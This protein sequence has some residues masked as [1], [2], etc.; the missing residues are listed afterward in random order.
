MVVI[1]NLIYKKCIM[2]TNVHNYTVQELIDLIELPQKRYY[3]LDEIEQ[4]ISQCIKQVNETN[5]TSQSKQSL[6]TFLIQSFE[7]I[8][9]EHSVLYGSDIIQTIEITHNYH[10]T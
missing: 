10:F 2:D 1:A 5:D 6:N 7:K 8:C 4:H 3:T 9:D